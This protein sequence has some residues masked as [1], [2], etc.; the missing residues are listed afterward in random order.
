MFLEAKK[1]PAVDDSPRTAE[2]AAFLT[3]YV[4]SAGAPPKPP[5]LPAEWLGFETV[6]VVMMRAPIERGGTKLTGASSGRLL[7]HPPEPVP[8]YSAVYGEHGGTP[9]SGDSLAKWVLEDLNI[10]SEGARP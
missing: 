6:V 7:F 2:E 4:A 3:Q 5:E 10:R 9:L 1:G 8:V